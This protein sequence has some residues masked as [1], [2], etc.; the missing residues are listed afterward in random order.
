MD[1]AIKVLNNSFSKFLNTREE[2]DFQFRL[3]E[4]YVKN[5]EPEKALELYQTIYNAKSNR[6][7]E[8]LSQ[9]RMHL[10]T[11]GNLEMY[12]KGSDFDKYILLQNV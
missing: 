12:V 3:A 9:T 2:F 4:L 8:L 7:L 10:Y 6:R 11:E 1:K 5:S